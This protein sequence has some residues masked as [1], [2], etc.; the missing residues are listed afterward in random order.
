MKLDQYL[1][2]LEDFAKS[3]KKML[4]QYE[5]LTEDQKKEVDE[6]KQKV[7]ER[8]APQLKKIEKDL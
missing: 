7:K 4:D 3:Y 8:I 2:K 5:N 6:I 1:D